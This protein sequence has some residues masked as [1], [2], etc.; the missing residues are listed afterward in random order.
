MCRTHLAMKKCSA[1]A[2]AREI[3]RARGRGIER[4]RDLHLFTQIEG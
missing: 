1:K 2:R 4:A 3:A